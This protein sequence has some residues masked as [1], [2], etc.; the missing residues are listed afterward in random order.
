MW[1]EH[2]DHTHAH[3]RTHTKTHTHTHTHTRTKGRGGK[4]F[5][6]S[7]ANTPRVFPEGEREGER[8]G[9]GGVASTPCP[10]AAS[11]PPEPQS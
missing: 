9:E 3:A 6:S 8:K 11:V 4:F 10:R 1:R 2:A 5:L 7:L